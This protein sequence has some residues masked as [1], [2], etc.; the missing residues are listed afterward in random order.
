MVHNPFADNMSGEHDDGAVVS[1][2]STG[3]G[4]PYR[5]IHSDPEANAPEV[6]DISS[7]PYHYAQSPSVVSR[8][9]TGSSP[10]T[11]HSIA[12]SPEVPGQHY[13]QG[14]EVFHGYTDYPQV[15]GDLNT[16]A[17]ERKGAGAA[18]AAAGGETA[19]AGRASGKKIM[20][21]RR[22]VFF[23]VLAVVC[24]AIAVAVGAGVGA[25]VS[26]NKSKSPTE[27]SKATPTGGHTGGSVSSPSSG[28]TS[29]SSAGGSSTTLSPGSSPSASPT[30]SSDSTKSSGSS[31]TSSAT[32]TPTFLNQTTLTNDQG[33]GF[34]G[35]AS[36]DFAGDYTLVFLN[37]ADFVETEKGL[38]FKIAINS[39]QWLQK[40]TNCCVSF[41]NNSTHAGWV[42]YQCQAKKQPK[43][44]ET[45]TRVWVWCSD[46][47]Q[48]PN[49]ERC[50]AA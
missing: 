8:T 36:T 18:G 44:T 2:M 32:P 38:D 49:A 13:D 40:G 12:Y 3:T 23:I 37:D 1:P 48:Q 19:A 21:M 26:S 29:G 11:V 17:D 47:H 43:T 20:G 14:K 35:F 22:T 31:T 42:G 9:V 7:S 5:S 50:G 33:W 28:S 24:I 39:Y 25:T 15:V 41:C 4:Q 10:G 45:F 30:K 16:K 34:Q 27:E 46:D 6:V